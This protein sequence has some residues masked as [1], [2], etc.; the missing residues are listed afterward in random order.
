MAKDERLHILARRAPLIDLAGLTARGILKKSG[1]WY[2]LLKPEEL[3]A[4]VLKQAT[5]VSKTTQDGKVT[6]IKLQFGDPGRLPGK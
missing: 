6:E 4:H 2:I 3:P 1:E 5:S